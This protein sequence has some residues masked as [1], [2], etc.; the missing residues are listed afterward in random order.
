MFQRRIP[1]SRDAHASNPHALERRRTSLRSCLAALI[2]PLG[3]VIAGCAGSSVDPART[4]AGESPGLDDA[5]APWSLFT[6]VRVATWFE[7]KSA[8]C[9]LAFDDTRRSHYEI[10]AP[11]LEARGIRGTFNLVPGE[12]WDWG[13]WQALFDAG[14]EIGNHTLNHYYFKDLT[15]E[16]GD[17]EVREGQLSLVQNIRGLD[18]VETFTYPGGSAPDW[19]GEVV[20]R[21]HRFARVG[22]GVNPAAPPDLLFTTGSGYYAPFVL[23]DMRANLS[24]ALSS[25]GWYLPYYHSIVDGPYPRRLECPR[26]LFTAHLDQI[27][28]ERERLWIAP[29]GTVSKYILER[30]G[31]RYDYVTENGHGLLVETG[32]DPEI[33]DVPLTLVFTLASNL[34][35]LEITIGDGEPIRTRGRQSFVAN[36]LP[37]ASIRIRSHRIAPQIGLSW[38]PEADARPVAPVFWTSRNW[39]AGKRNDARTVMTLA[40]TATKM[41]SVAMEGAERHPSMSPAATATVSAS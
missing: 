25:G 10:V 19:A 11:E 8:A 20:G 30:E 35:D 33:F 41:M 17:R 28:G 23:D 36:V 31:F 32:L 16:Q 27:V 34:P 12:I 24:L 1:A 26:E 13:P 6:D 3:F 29:Q 18:R 38:I 5:Y 2:L 21:Y 7:D 37:G 9:S 4:A 22:Q 14:H 40:K 39:T 15:P